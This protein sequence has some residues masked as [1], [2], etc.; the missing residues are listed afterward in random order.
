M[1]ITAKGVRE[2]S[3]SKNNRMKSRAMAEPRGIFGSIPSHA[4]QCLRAL[5]WRG[6]KLKP[7]TAQARPAQDE[8]LRIEWL[9]R[10]LTFLPE[11]GG[12]RWSIDGINDIKII[13]LLF[14][15]YF[16][17]KWLVPFLSI[18]VSNEKTGHKY[19]F[20]SYSFFL[21]C[22]THRMPQ[23]ND[24]LILELLTWMACSSWI[25]LFTV[26]QQYRTTSTQLTIQNMRRQEILLQLLLLLTF[27][28][29]Y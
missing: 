14:Q 5:H 19:S 1:P 6:F 4:T 28:H 23:S 29:T 13:I 2:Y 3:E 9:P 27:R 8:G 24:R 20:N 10:V 21:L 12:W 25:V 17:K 22:K 7:T 15:Q 16:L 26:E 11:P 18:H